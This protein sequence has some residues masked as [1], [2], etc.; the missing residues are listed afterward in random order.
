M[1]RSECAACGAA[2][3][4]FLDLGS[5]PLA[6]R[7]PASPGEHEEWYPLVV[8]VCPRCWLVQLREVVPDGELF[9]PD[10][11]F[12]TGGSPAAVR[13]FARMAGQLLS[14]YPE[15]ARRLTVEIACND[16]TLLRNFAAAGCRTVGVEPAKPAAAAAAATGLDVIAEPF[17]RS[18]VPAVRG[19]HGPA[20]LVL[21]CN[22]AA[23]VADPVDF[24][25]GVRDLLA[26]DGI[27]VV[28]FQH[29]AE[30]IAG[31]Q[32]DH[33]YHEHRFFYSL[34][35][36]SHIAAI[37]G[38]QVT[39]WRRTPAQGG[40]LRVTLAATRS[41]HMPDPEPWLQSMTVYDGMQARAAYIRHRL[42]DL[43]DAELSA[44]RTVAGYGA[45]AK[46]ATL[47]NFCGI[48]AD[49]LPWIEDITPAKTGRFTPG[50]HIPIIGPGAPPDT[51][52]LLVW[53]YLASVL[54]RERVFLN[55]GGRF[56]VPG[57]VPVIL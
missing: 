33:V 54:R 49:L 38:L 32:F 11:G 7:F 16:G 23:H 15:Q 39:H 4:D 25:G 47:L 2:L 28:E 42:L 12:L 27:A 56:I 20:G 3:H 37:A 13:Y 35:S 43:I 41:R 48:D 21:A 10:Y 55:D 57:A 50:T 46:S 6:D 40:T 14:T 22:V 52:L 29:V 19:R 26:G 30:L 18:L 34:A 51:Y 8:A 17:T 5:T 36:F 45:S 1:R 53:N 44:A 9:G 31:C 24:L